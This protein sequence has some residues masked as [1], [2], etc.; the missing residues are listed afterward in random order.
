[1]EAKLFADEGAAI[2]TTFASMAM[3]HFTSLIRLE[4]VVWPH[5]REKLEA[6]IRGICR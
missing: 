4:F 3:T 5:Q 1:V 6:S 2:N